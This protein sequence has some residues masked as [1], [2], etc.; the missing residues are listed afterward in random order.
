M[1]AFS[2]WLSCGKAGAREDGVDLAAQDRDLARA[3]VVGGG[4]V[5]AE[6]A[7]LADDPARRRRT[8]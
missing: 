6:E 1:S 5:E 8:A 3:G 2:L 4:R 7:A